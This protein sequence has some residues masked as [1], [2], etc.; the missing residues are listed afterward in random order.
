[1]DVGQLVSTL[2]LQ[3]HFIDMI[4]STGCAEHTASTNQRAR[5]TINILAPLDTR[6]R[7]RS[8]VMAADNIHK[9][10]SKCAQLFTSPWS[11]IPQLVVDVTQHDQVGD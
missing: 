8:F 6:P 2:A 11:I 5:E 10:K 3:R 1:M 9:R 7:E 4:G